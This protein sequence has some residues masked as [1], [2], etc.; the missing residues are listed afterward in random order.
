MVASA[1]AGA[2]A[3]APLWVLSSHT[4]LVS[5]TRVAAI[6][7]LIWSMSEMEKKEIFCE[8][9]YEYKD[10]DDISDWLAVSETAIDPEPTAGNPCH[11]VEN[12]SQESMPSQPCQHIRI[13][14]RGSNH[15]CY[16]ERCLDCGFL[17]LKRSK[18][19]GQKTQKTKDQ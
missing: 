16:Q 14:R 13:S 6:K 11:S 4:K 1:L 3:V 18:G 9:F 12:A 10:D 17:L 8:I 15:F 2:F 5:W 19:N 7:I